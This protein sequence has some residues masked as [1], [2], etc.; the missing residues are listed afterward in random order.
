MTKDLIGNSV[1]S[2]DERQPEPGYV[3]WRED[4]NQKQVMVHIK[5][6]EMED[7]WFGLHYVKDIPY[8]TIGSKIAKGK[9]GL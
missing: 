2:T 6:I 8:A 4:K 1:W 7:A 9:Y 3:I 5:Y